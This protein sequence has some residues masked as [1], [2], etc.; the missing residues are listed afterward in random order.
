MMNTSKR[1]FR[2]PAA[3]EAVAAAALLGACAPALATDPVQCL[4]E[5]A[6]RVTLR[7]AVPAQIVGMHVDRGSLVKKGQLLVTLDAGVEKAALAQARY[8]SVM[9]GQLRAAESKLMNAQHKFRRREELQQQKFVSLQDRDDAE[10]DMRIAEAD[11]LE[12]KDNR[13]LSRL[14]AVRLEAEI[15]RRQLTSPFNGVVTERL[16]HPGELAQVGEGSGP[17]L[18]LAQTDPARVELVLPAA[19][20]GKLRVGQ[21]VQVRTEAPFN[22]SFAAVVRVVDA[23]IDAPSGTFGVRLEAA[24]PNQEI[25]LGVKCSADLT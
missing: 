6:M 14:D 21:T 5:P 22:K 13:E 9:Q 7:S 2:I 25:P 8:R 20:F 15:G 23:V 11:V 10:A 17:I 4:I 16:Q 19:R 12:A 3:R 24:N 18:K 1:A